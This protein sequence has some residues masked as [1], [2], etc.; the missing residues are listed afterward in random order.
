MR[1]GNIDIEVER[2]ISSTF[3]LG[4]KLLNNSELEFGS[5]IIDLGFE[6]ISLGIFKN[7]ALIHSITFPIGVN[8]I[9]KD[10]SKVCSLDLDESN[11]IRDNIDFAF[12]NNQSI[13][14]KNNHL[15]INYFINSKFRKISKNLILNVIKARAEEVIDKLKKQIIVPGFQL[16]P[17]TNILLTGGGSNFINIEK[18]FSNFFGPNINKMDNSI[19]TE[20]QLEKKFTSCLGALKI[21]KDGWE[22]EAIPQTSEKNIQKV[23]FF[24]KIFGIH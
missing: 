14:D 15:K 24:A 23:G 16:T 3:A 17:G 4:V 18:Y 1:Q 6:K 7:F 10:L 8:H 19:E 13:F 12:E 2:L 5:I 9:T 11:S 20:N 22:T 21:I